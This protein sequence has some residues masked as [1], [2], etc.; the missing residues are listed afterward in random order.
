MIIEHGSAVISLARLKELER[1]EKEF[2]ALAEKLREEL[3]KK[4]I[5]VDFTWSRRKLVIGAGGDVDPSVMKEFVAVI[6]D[7]N[8]VNEGLRARLDEVNTMSVFRLVLKKLTAK[9]F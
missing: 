5:R 2:D 6:N 7:R 3:E 8:D 4:T 9:T 1:K